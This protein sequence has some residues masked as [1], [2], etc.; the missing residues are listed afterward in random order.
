M[1]KTEQAYAEHLR[2]RLLA[3]EIAEFS[4]EPVKLRLANRTHYTP[5]FRVVKQDGLIEM[6]EVKGFWEEDAR[7]KIKV[8]AELHP[9]VFIAVKRVAQREGGGW[10]YERFGGT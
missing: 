7:V 10:S 9:Y 1:N 8:A 3:G 6:H 2:Q 4:Y 5:D